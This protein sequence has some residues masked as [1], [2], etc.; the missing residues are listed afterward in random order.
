LDDP[1]YS[2]GKKTWE[3][4]TKFP[5]SN[6]KIDSFERKQLEIKYQQRI[7]TTEGIPKSKRG[8]NNFPAVL[9]QLVKRRMVE[10]Q[11][12]PAD[13]TNDFTSIML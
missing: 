6:T 2:K 3:P 1:P 10:L 9:R 8:A 11:L 4:N 12:A 5:A 13:V 7:Y